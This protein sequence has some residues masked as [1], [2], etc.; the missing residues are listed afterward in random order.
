[1]SSI[2]DPDARSDDRP[3]TALLADPD[4]A[5][6]LLVAAMFGE[7]AGEFPAVA[8]EDVGT[9]VFL[10]AWRDQLRPIAP[11][12][13]SMTPRD[14]PLAGTH[15]IPLAEKALGGGAI[16]VPLPD[17]VEYARVLLGQ[18]LCVALADAGWAC[19]AEPGRPVVMVRDNQS[20]EP[21]TTLE[22]YAAGKMSADEWRKV[23]E[24]AGML[25]QPLTPGA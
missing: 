11:E 13:A 14:L 5:E 22:Q 8:W 10:P 15:L 4:A 12:L 19:S 18:A 7:E 20:M 6:R 24:E 1:V 25:D 9:E 3:G 17:L 2:V 16:D 21:Y 23:W